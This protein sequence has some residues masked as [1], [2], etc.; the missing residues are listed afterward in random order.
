MNKP[1]ALAIFLV[2]TGLFALAAPPGQGEWKNTTVI[3]PVERLE[4]NANAYIRNNP[5]SG[6]GYYVLGRIQ[7]MVFARAAKTLALNAARP[8]PDGKPG[9]PGFPPW[10]SA[11]EKPTGKGWK[12]DARSRRYLALSIQNYRKASEL[13]PKQAIYVMGLGWMLEQALAVGAGPAD[14][15]TKKERTIDEK[16]R[17]QVV[18]LGDELHVRVFNSVV[19]HF[20][21]MARTVR[22]HVR[23]TGSGVGCGGNRR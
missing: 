6:W 17:A 1:R 21:K 23:H 16:A 8:G 19:Y 3:L 15:L 11:Q 2:A 4:K 18:G 22:S 5:T 12:F 9:T 13:D 7:S 10:D 20:D 14:V